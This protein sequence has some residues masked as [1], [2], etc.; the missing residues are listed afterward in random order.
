MPQVEK[1]LRVVNM[2]YLCTV[3]LVLLGDSFSLFSLHP[4]AMGIFWSLFCE[5]IIVQKY[6]KPS[7]H[8][9][10]MIFAG[11]VAFLGASIIYQVKERKGSDHF[12]T[13]HGLYGGL[14]VTVVGAQLFGGLFFFGKVKSPLVWYLHKLFGYTIGF[15]TWY[16]GFLHMLGES[17]W[18]MSHRTVQ[19][20]L[21][22]M[23]MGRISYI[24]SGIFFL[25]V[26]FGK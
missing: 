22:I 16:V 26:S 13:N 17:G 7:T 2:V 11:L 25:F 5:G 10:F 4:L 20:N 18:F 8:R 24:I 9:L 15:G 12:L 6:K 3:I 1:A 23:S 21:T 14:V 19:Q